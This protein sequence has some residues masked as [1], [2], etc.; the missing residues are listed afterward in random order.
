MARVVARAVIVAALV[1][2]GGAYGSTDEQDVC[3]HAEV[4]TARTIAPNVVTNPPP[5][6]RDSIVSLGVRE[7]PSTGDLNG[8][9]Q[10][11]EIVPFLFPTPGS[12]PRLVPTSGVAW[13]RFGDAIG[14]RQHEFYVGDINGDGDATDSTI[15]L[16]VPGDRQ[17]V[18]QTG[19]PGQ[20]RA[21]WQKWVL[22]EVS[23][24]D[25]GNQ[26][27]NGDG[28]TL[29]RVWF[30]LDTK[31]RQVQN[32]G[33]AVAHTGAPV[34]RA[35]G[36][37][38]FVPEAGQGRTDLNGDGDAFDQQVSF[39]VAPRA[40]TAWNLGIS[41]HS[42][43][44]GEAGIV[45]AIQEASERRDLNGDGD[46]NDIVASFLPKIGEHFVPPENL[47]VALARQ[48]GTPRVAV[49]FRLIAM[50]VDEASQLED[51]DGDGLTEDLVLHV[52]RREG[53]EN[54]G[55]AMSVAPRFSGIRV[56]ERGIWFY[57]PS[58]SATLLAWF[59]EVGPVSLGRFGYLPIEVG[60]DAIVT[61]PE[62]D[63]DFTGD[64]DTRDE[65]LWLVDQG[66]QIAA[67]WETAVGEMQ[68]SRSGGLVWAKEDNHRDLNGDGDRSDYV[69]F[70]LLPGCRRMAMLNYT[71]FPTG[72][73]IWTD[74]KLAL[75]TARTVGAA[76][77]VKLLTFP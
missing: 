55:V 42:V 37:L 16:F 28:D 68:G 73:W 60:A 24:A 74:G 17:P 21:G 12:D 43:Y 11:G 46:R 75:F 65:V 39:V 45:M 36:F 62:T 70:A 44:S 26:D 9:G 18:W 19:L 8:N 35:D 69:A 77:E 7:T 57:E 61:V 56:H 15:E 20:A 38:F 5:I 40:G 1:W 51:L 32:L 67:R 22:A 13:T 23:E 25:Q 27:L 14:Y 52:L 30:L 53:F 10:S 54:T 4:L 58:D 29:D 49:G 3:A 50:G 6:L 72:Q 59:E 31:R 2:P 41:T 48:S 33:L 66:G 64:G 71:T 63:Q 76:T 34:A 47:G